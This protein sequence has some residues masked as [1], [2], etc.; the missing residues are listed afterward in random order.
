MNQFYAGIASGQTQRAMREAKLRCSKAAVNTEAV[1][2]GA[3]FE[4]YIGSAARPADSHCP[5]KRRQRKSLVLGKRTNFENW[6]GGRDSNPDRQIQS[7][8]S[9]RWTTSQQHRLS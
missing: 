7:L 9:Y 3:S 5:K 1:L 2:L 6:L 8:Q 4:V